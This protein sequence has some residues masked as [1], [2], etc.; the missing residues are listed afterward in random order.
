MSPK[1]FLV[2][3]LLVQIFFLPVISGYFVN[4]K[5]LLFFHKT[6]FAVYE[7]ERQKTERFKYISNRL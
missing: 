7:K 6:S 5:F 3:V 4:T 2:S 1:S